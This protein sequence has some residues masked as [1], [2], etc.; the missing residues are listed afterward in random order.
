MGTI[1]LSTVDNTEVEVEAGEFFSEFTHLLR[2][3]ADPTVRKFR[4]TEWKA[5]CK[6]LLDESTYRK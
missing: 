4:R 6:I 3:S 5:L 1:P 2:R